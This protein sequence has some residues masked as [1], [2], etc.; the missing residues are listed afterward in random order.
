[1]NNTDTRNPL[2]AAAFDF[3][4]DDAFN[5]ATVGHLGTVEQMRERGDELAKALR[6]VAQRLED[7]HEWVHA[8]KE[9]E[10]RNIETAAFDQE[11]AAAQARAFLC[12]D[13][14]ERLGTR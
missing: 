3:L 6:E 9:T 12:E 7:I 2:A 5:I 11:H 8:H 10:E 13:L 4:A 1:M 14:I